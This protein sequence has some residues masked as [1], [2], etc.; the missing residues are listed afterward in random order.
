[1]SG[2]RNYGDSKIIQNLIER[3]PKGHSKKLGSKR[4]KSIIEDFNTKTQYKYKVCKQKGHN[5][6]TCKGKKL[7]DIDKSDET[8]GDGEELS[9]TVTSYEHVREES[10]TVKP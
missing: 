5:S 10:D 7:L 4:I 2:D 6:K 9:T 8:E 3:R 1:M